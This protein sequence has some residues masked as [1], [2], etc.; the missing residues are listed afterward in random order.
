MTLLIVLNI[1]ALE[2]DEI[3]NVWKRIWGDEEEN[4]IQRSY[5]ID[6]EEYKKDGSVVIH[7]F[8]GF[9]KRVSKKPKKS[10]R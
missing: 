6:C 3:I 1:S 2:K 7:L 4:K 10:H 8:L 9:L 5:Y